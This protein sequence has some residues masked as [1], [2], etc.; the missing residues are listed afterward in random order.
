[1]ASQGERKKKRKE[2]RKKEGKGEK[3]EGKERDKGKKRKGGEKRITKGR[4][5]H[6]YNA[7]FS[8]FLIIKMQNVYIISVSYKNC[9]L[10]QFCTFFS[11]SAQSSTFYNNFR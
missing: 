4:S 1:M 6:P 7:P 9:N 11:R 8:S 2:R 5:T 3:E 10:P